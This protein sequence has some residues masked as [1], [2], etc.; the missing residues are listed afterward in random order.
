VRV[1]H[2]HGARRCDGRIFHHAQDFEREV[3][4]ARFSPH[5]R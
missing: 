1:A 4:H 2:T 3:E 5:G